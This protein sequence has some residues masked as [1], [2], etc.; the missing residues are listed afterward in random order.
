[1]VL[2]RGQQVGDSSS[3]DND[4]YPISTGNPMVTHTSNDAS[5]ITVSASG[6]ALGSARK[7]VH[8]CQSGRLASTLTSTHQLGA[9]ARLSTKTNEHQI[10]PATRYNSSP[11]SSGLHT[12]DNDR[13]S[14]TRFDTQGPSTL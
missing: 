9:H 7:P 13:V 1:M 8:G 5:G 3:A 10:A 2:T 4:R 12:S 14:P 11:I 6:D